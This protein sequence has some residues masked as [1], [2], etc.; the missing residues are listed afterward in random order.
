M[1]KD[2][3][4]VIDLLQFGA[5]GS[6][7]SGSVAMKL[8]QS[9]LNVNSL[10]TLDT[11]RKDEWLLYDR[12]V[13]EV[14][15]VQL[16]GVADLMNAGLTMN[17]PNAFG[18]TVIQWEKQSDM[19]PAQID[20]HG[21]TQGNN[22][23]LDY[24]L[25]NVPVPIVHKDFQLNIRQL[26]ASRNGGTPLDTTQASVATRRVTDTLESM[27]FNGANITAG[28]GTIHGYTNFPARN[29]DSLT[30]SWATI[31][32]DQ[33]VSDVLS[34]IEA[35]SAD[36]MYGPFQLYIPISY[37]IALLDDYKANSDKS[38]I[39]RLLEIPQV[40][41]IKQTS[42]LTDSVLMI[43]MTSDVV[44]MVVG[45]QPMPLMWESHGGMVFNFK[46]L[47]IMVP[48]L[49]SDYDGRCGIAHFSE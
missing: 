39:M 32:G 33:I 12:K 43:Q 1:P 36:N 20:M 42:Q 14:A 27:L 23:K 38:I 47:A 13:I 49:K 16:V 34:M 41:G 45:I 28:G 19:T 31:T 40:K 3:E 29:V 48:R 5:G 25:V 2:N 10:R 46:V 15:R 18:H 17:L 35:L 22:D 37:Y 26:A 44:D 11:L 9:G 7:G 8:L 4:Q 21:T 6:T 30:G 24:S